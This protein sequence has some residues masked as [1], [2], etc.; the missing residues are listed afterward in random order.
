MKL[1]LKYSIRAIRLFPKQFITAMGLIALMTVLDA[2]TP[3]GLRFYIA[4]VTRTNHM[5]TFVVGLLVFAFYYLLCIGIR[6][7]WYVALDRFGGKYIDQL[8]VEMQSRMAETP[9]SEIEKEQP[10]IIR[11][12][13]FTDVLNVFRVV[14]HHLPS[15]LNSMAIIIVALTISAMYDIRITTIIALAIMLGV[16]LSWISRKVLAKSAGATNAKL[17]VHDAWCTH[18]VQMLPVIHTHN[19]LSYFQRNSTKNVSEFIETSIQED[20]RTLFWSELINNYHALF[21]VALSAL[22]AMPLA[23]NS[24]AD[25]VFYTMISSLVMNQAQSAELLFQQIIKSH[26]SFKH[27]NELNQLPKRRG[28]QTITS[29]RTIE[30]KNV[31]FVYTNGIHALKQASCI[32]NRGDVVHLQGPNGSGKS[33]FIKLLTGLYEPSAGELSFNGI[34]SIHFSQASRNESILY[35]GQDDLCLNEDFNTY[36]E[37]M[38]GEAIPNEWYVRLLSFVGLPDDERRISENGLSLSVGQRK[39]LL[40]MQMLL[41][42]EK[43]S[44]IIMDEVTAGL[45]VDTTK[46]VNKYVTNL[47]AKN[48]KIIIFVDHTLANNLPVTKKIIFTE[49]YLEEVRNEC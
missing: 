10:N 22:L 2:A 9:Y 45:D 1:I 32:I 20:R 16:L 27:I 12:I 34:S 24:V 11:N 41:R 48:D 40:F 15:L 23:Q 31:N 7:A 6:I 29:I 8:T 5:N 3:W 19:I 36:L 33:T 25:L 18:F 46:K 13:L 35:I 47:A 49:G 38:T 42:C 30:Y 39:K 43:A 4:E 14:G 26:I 37:V 21:S 28:Q 44:V 17:K